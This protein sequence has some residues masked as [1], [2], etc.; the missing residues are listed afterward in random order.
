M[1]RKKLKLSDSVTKQHDQKD[2]E[3]EI[4]IQEKVWNLEQIL[5]K[6]LLKINFKKSDKNIAAVYNPLDYAA[7]IHLKYLK[8]LKHKPEVLFLGN[9]FYR[10]NL[11]IF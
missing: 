1:L 5:C 6:D 10:F 2:D 8:F 9:Y 4:S 3:E 7:D 11:F